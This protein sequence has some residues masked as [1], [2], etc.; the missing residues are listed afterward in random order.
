MQNIAIYRRFFMAGTGE[1]GKKAAEHTP[2]EVKSE[3]GRK[4]AEAL[5]ADQEKKSAAS[6]KAAETRKKEDPEAFQKM[7]QKGGSHSQ[8]GSGK[9]ENDE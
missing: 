1:G 3:R 2:D 7:G 9:Q 8:G 5:N 4:G 6:H